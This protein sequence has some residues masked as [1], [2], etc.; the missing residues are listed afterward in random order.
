MVLP[1]PKLLLHA[2]VE[3]PLAVIFCDAP[4]QIEPPPAITVG[5]GLTVITAFAVLVHPLASV[6]VT[7]YVV[8]V[9][10]LTVFDTPAPK[11]LLHE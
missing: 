7:V 5:N 1:L 8:V 2:Y 10:G 11:L 6:P 9:V 3:A 4:K